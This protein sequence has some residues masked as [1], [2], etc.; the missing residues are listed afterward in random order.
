[1]Q[2][3]LF[4]DSQEEYL[5]ISV[6]KPGYPTV[7]R[8]V[9]VTLG[10]LL[11]EQARQVIRFWDDPA[12]PRQTVNVTCERCSLSDCTDRAVPATELVKRE[13]RKRMNDVLK[14]LTG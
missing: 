1:M 6:A 3:A 2:R 14:K 4:L 10:I 8:N 7:N 12:I 11:D 5:C 9:S 13:A